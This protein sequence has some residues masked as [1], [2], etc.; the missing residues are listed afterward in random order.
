TETDASGAQTI[1]VAKVDT[2]PPDFE[3]GILDAL[4][5]ARIEVARLAFFAHGTTVVINALTERKGVRTGLVTTRGFRDI[6]EIGR[7]NR[8]R[9]FD[10]HYRKPESFAPRELRREVAGRITW[11][12]E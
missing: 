7:G 10:L 4:D 5:K 1:R 6:L 2:T 9:F 12:G 11:R 3:R 8:P